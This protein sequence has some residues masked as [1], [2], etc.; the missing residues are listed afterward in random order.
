MSISTF[1]VYLPPSMGLPFLA[2]MITP[3]GIVSAEAFDS[4]D[5]AD[6][7]NQRTQARIF[8]WKSG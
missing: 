3:G 2:V 4:A 6:A 5:L 1:A 7:H 8:N